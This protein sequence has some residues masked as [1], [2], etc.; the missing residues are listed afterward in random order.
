MNNYTIT[1]YAISLTGSNSIAVNTGTTNFLTKT[2][3]TK[4]G[5]IIYGMSVNSFLFENNNGESAG[6]GGDG[7]SDNNTIFSA[8]DNSSICNF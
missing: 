8:A 5:V 7:G 2:N 6:Y 1:N 3:T 4:S